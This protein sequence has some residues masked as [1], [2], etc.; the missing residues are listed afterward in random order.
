MENGNS[1]SSTGVASAVSSI[2]HKIRTPLTV[3][4]ST[5][6]NFLDGAFGSLTDEQKKWIKKMEVHTAHLEGLLNE[7]LDMLR[8]TGKADP[9]MVQEHLEEKQGADVIKGRKNP[10]GPAISAPAGFSRTP[11]ILAVDD[12]EDILDVIKEGLGSKGFHVATASDGE[13]ALRLALKIK[14]D[15]VLMDVH[16]KDQN[17]LSIGQEIKSRLVTYTPVIIVTG[18]DDLREKLSG[19]EFAADDLLSKPFQMVELFVRVGSMLRLKKLHET[20]EAAA[21]KE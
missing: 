7:I 1:P 9:L 18:Q 13:E 10:S 3:I 16:L 21:R 17:G 19:A 6:N 8:A 15:L 11:V 20:L 2:A 5:V 14:P 4:M 12:E